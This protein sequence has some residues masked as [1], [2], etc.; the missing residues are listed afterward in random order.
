MKDR[1][2]A[3]TITPRQLHALGALGAAFSMNPG[4]V[5]LHPYFKAHPGKMDAIKAMLPKF[6]AKTAAEKAMLF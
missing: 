2:L 1:S 3:A 4:F 6:T 5:R